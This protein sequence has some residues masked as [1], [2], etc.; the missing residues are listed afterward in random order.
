MVEV[1]HV[2]DRI[3]RAVFGLLF[4]T[5]A[6][7]VFVVERSTQKIVS[8]NLRAADMLMREPGTFVGLAIAELACEPERDLLAP[9]HYEEVGLRR[10]DDYPIYVALAVAHIESE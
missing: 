10:G 5:S 7:A 1:P 6:E 2:T 3:A 4:E 9:G 8:A